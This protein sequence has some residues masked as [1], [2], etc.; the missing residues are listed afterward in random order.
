MFVVLVSG[1]IQSEIVAMVK[2]GRSHAAR[3]IF[4]VFVLSTAVTVNASVKYV[5][6]VTEHPAEDFHEPFKAELVLS[7]DVFSTG[8]AEGADIE[9]LQITAGP[10]AMDE[11]ALTLAQMHTSF[12][13]WSVTLSEDK[14]S[15]HL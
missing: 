10:T 12:V 15:Q 13:N 7:D 2:G 1:F 6:I 11:D 8:M 5:F 14:Q 4:A 9:S 3:M